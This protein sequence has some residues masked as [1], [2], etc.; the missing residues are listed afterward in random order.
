MFKYVFDDR[1]ETSGLDQIKGFQAAEILPDIALNFGGSIQ[2][3]VVKCAADNG[4]FLQKALHFFIQSIQ[5]GG[6]HAMDSCGDIRRI[7]LSIQK[8]AAVLID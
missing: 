3:L 2:N 1:L 4:R 6:D 7:D 8:P 5:P